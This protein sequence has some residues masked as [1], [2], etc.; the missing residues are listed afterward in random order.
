MVDAQYHFELADIVLALD[1]DFLNCGP[2]HV[3]YQRNFCSRRRSE[4]DRPF[5]NRLYVVE[6]TPSGTGA[7]ADHRLPLRPGLIKDFAKAL[8]VAVPIWPLGKRG[9][10]STCSAPLPRFPV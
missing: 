7:L 8:A 3:R 10:R 9:N 6:S 1:A 5:M 4:R 2:G